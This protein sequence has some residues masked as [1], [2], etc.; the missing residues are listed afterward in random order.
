MKSI[1]DLESFMCAIA[2][3]LAEIRLLAVYKC[4]TY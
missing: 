3:I 2:I 4:Y 1:S